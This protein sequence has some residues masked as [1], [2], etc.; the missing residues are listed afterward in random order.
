M[1]SEAWPQLPYAEWAPTKKTLHM[2][3]QML[4]K[5]RLALEP[6]Q[7]EWLNACLHLDPFG[8]TTGAMPVGERIVSAGI[9][10]FDS[11][12]WV[13][14]SDGT[15]ESIPIG[16]GSCV[17]EI[18]TLY[19]EALSWLGVEANDWDKPQEVADLTPFPENDHDCTLV[20][21]HA[22]QFHRLLS[23]IDGIDEEFRS[24]FFGRTGV[25]FWWGAFDFSVLLFNGKHAQAPDD[26]GYIMR[27]DL[28]AE[29]LNVGFWTGDDSSPEPLFYGY[30]V[31]RPDGCEIAQMQPVYVSWVEALEEWVLP[32][33]AVRKCDDPRQ[34]VLDF[35]WSVYGV[36]IE[37]AGW[38]EKAFQYAQPR[39]AQRQA[40]PMRR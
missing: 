35:L 11:T 12:M 32:Y 31:P 24:Q 26:R 22:Q 18:W 13:R 3:T 37:R 10:V 8:F 29:H 4:G 5:T 19:S 25:Q 34:T 9:D 39:S 15:S 33:D 23:A 17:A 30:L 38:D 36:A 28:D 2:C 16:A 6:P 40:V 14:S 1:S 27:Y 21:E 20:P 7:P